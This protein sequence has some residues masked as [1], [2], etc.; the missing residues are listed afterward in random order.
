MIY[1]F[2]FEIDESFTIMIMGIFE[3][4]SS[5]LHWKEEKNVFEKRLQKKDIHFLHCRYTTNF[6]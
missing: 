2:K 1:K 6:I 3:H 5:N 4:Q